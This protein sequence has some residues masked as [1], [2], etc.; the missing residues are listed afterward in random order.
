MLSA[1][2]E[3]RLRRATHN[4]VRSSRI[5]EENAEIQ[6]FFD[7]LPYLRSEARAVVD[8]EVIRTLAEI[9]GGD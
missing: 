6:Y 9:V 3:E 8:D 4:V 7:L 1:R 5:H 2:D